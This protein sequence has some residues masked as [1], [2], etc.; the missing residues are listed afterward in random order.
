MNTKLQAEREIGII[1]NR[2]LRKREDHIKR[3]QLEYGYDRENA[4]RV[5]DYHAIKG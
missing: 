4:E 5:M 2:H 3:I 1:Q